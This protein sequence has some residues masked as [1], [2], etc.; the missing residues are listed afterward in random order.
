MTL[1]FGWHK[2]IHLPDPSAAPT[3][4]QVTAKTT[5]LMAVI[6]FILQNKANYQ[7]YINI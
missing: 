6:V 4:K 3:S 7:N 2:S 1:C 5:R